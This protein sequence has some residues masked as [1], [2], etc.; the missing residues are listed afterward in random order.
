VSRSGSAGETATY[1]LYRGLAWWAGRL[2]TALGRRVFMALGS[3][4]HAS[5]PKVRSTVAANQA[6][7]LG[8]EPNDPLVA[9]STRAAFRLY[10]RYWFD[11]FDAIDWSDERISEAFEWENL[12]LFEDPLKA[13]TGAIAVLPHF[14]NWDVAGRAM[15][16]QGMPVLSVAERL[17][18]ER[19]FELFLEHRRALGMD[20]VA[21]DDKR[22]GRA[23]A[24]AI[25]ANRIVALVCD[26]DL[27]GRG[28]PVQ[29]FGAT[30]RM[31]LGP[32][33]LALSTGAPL[34]AAA[35]HNTD[36]G[37][38][39]VLSSVDAPRSG[40]RR[41]DAAALTEAIAAEFERIISTYPADWHMFQ[42]GWE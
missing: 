41:A 1:W 23:L 26:R 33:M 25:S 13:G 4:A 10:A 19:L 34:V 17:R 16:A 38:T 32:A 3:A 37:W 29:M 21:L 5:L 14:G 31:P 18:P 7:V 9:S 15:T 6:R 11:T 27:T 35:V 12:E 42:P 22:V 36:E 28:L 30:R 24:Q 2:P 20:I 39:C 8:R 40:E